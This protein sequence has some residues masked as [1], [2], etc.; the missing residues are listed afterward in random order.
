[1]LSGGVASHFFGI[2]KFQINIWR[3][4]QLIVN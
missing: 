4:I 2:T 1:L 3:L